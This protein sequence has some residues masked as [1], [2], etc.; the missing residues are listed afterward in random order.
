MPKVKQTKQEKLLIEKYS[1]IKPTCKCGC[2]QETRYE[3]KLKDFCQWIHGH[4]AKVKGHFGDPK[5]IKRV[6]KIIS[7]RKQKFESGE[8]DHVLKAI[9]EN[10]KDPELG[11]KISKGAKGI[12]KPKPKN[13]GVGRIQS[14]ITRQKMSESA[15]ENILKIGKVKRSNL[16]Y[17]FEGILQTLFVEF[18]HS[19][20]IKEVKKIYDFYLPEFNVLIEI[21]GDFW[22]CNPNTKYAIP[23]CKTQELNIEN[24]KI[25]NKWAFDNNYKLLRFW[26]YDIN[27]NLSQVIETLKK[28]LNLL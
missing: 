23:E 27:N 3:R 18:I 21:D 13:F 5:N 26:E 14:E 4:Q 24:D 6:E 16:E 9:K 12:A 15:I 7:T 25:K 17:K 10:R 19:F 1:G 11:A 22:H 8:Y 28:E 2:G 20:Y